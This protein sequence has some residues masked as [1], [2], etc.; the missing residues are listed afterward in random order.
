[1]IYK[2]KECLH[3]FNNPATKCTSPPYTSIFGVEHL[4]IYKNC[5]PK[6]ESEEIINMKLIFGIDDLEE[7]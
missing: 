6:C 1:M 5:C 7:D 2:C 4:G 3:D